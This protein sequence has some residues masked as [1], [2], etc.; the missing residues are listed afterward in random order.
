MV[1]DWSIAFKG[2]R[3]MKRCQIKIKVFDF[4]EGALCFSV[5][6]F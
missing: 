1:P 6:Y 5:D 4:S 3:Y 2:V